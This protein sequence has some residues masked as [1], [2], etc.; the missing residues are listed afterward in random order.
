MA[1]RGAPQLLVVNRAPQLP[2]WLLVVNRAPHGV[3][4]VKGG[5]LTRD[6]SELKEPMSGGFN[7]LSFAVREFPKPETDAALRCTTLYTFVLFLFV[8]FVFLG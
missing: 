4:I 8:V 5:L 3:R 7:E 6:S 2:P 1:P